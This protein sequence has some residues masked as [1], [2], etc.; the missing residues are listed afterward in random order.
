MGD[1]ITQDKQRAD[2][3]LLHAPNTYLRDE[4][5]VDKWLLHAANTYLW[6]EIGTK[7]IFGD[8]GII[9]PFMSFCWRFKRFFETIVLPFYH[10]KCWTNSTHSTADLGVGQTYIQ[11]AHIPQRKVRRQVNVLADHARGCFYVHYRL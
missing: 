1:R 8:L 7:Q 10:P 4:T 11:D 5:L 2:K 9:I 6:D 3:W